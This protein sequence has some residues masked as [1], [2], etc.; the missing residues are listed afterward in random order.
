ME[1]STSFGQSQQS[2]DQRDEYFRQMEELRTEYSANRKQIDLLSARLNDN[3]S[4]IHEMRRYISTQENKAS[5]LLLKNNELES[6]RS[7]L[8]AEIQ[9]VRDENIALREEVT[10]LKFSRVGKDTQSNLSM[11]EKSYEDTQYISETNLRQVHESP[12]AANALVFDTS[13]DEIN[14]CAPTPVQELSLI[15]I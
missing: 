13:Y 4:V 9:K 14:E 6:L 2:W 12:A 1:S 15:H 11:I 7:T 3:E 5:E 10:N 8:S